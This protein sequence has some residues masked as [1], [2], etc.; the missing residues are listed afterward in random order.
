MLMNKDVLEGKWKQ[1]RGEVK[2]WWGKLTDND[3]RRVDGNVDELTGLL[4][5]RYGYAR[6]EAKRQIEQHLG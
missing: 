4:Q 3:L 2:T 5:E 1:K 6:E